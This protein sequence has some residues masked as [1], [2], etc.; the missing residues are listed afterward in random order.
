MGL[1]LTIAA[2]LIKGL[3]G[4]KPIELVSIENKGTTFSFYLVDHED[5]TK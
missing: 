1:G 4:Q 2:K 5:E 3:S